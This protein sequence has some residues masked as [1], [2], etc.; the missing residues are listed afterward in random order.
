MKTFYAIFD[1]RG[2][3]LTVGCTN[4]DVVQKWLATKVGKL[5]PQGCEIKEIKDDGVASFSTK[6]VYFL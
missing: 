2:V 1:P 4:Y 6:N 5:L 3:Q